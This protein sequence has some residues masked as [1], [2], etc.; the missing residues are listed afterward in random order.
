MGDDATLF[1]V[2]IFAENELKF[3]SHRPQ[4]LSH[5][6]WSLFDVLIQIRDESAV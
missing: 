1:F 2:F 3:F 5:I 4:F 6:K